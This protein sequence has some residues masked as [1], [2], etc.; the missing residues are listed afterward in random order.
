MFFN[1]IFNGFLTDFTAISMLNLLFI[2]SGVPLR[3]GSSK[4]LCVFSCLLVVSKAYVGIFK[5]YIGI[6]RT[7][8]GYL[9]IC[10][11]FCTLV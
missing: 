8:I 6:F 5:A 2:S 4:I 1:W 3:A 9:Y 7:C 11:V 10:L